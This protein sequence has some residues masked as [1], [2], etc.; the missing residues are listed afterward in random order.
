MLWY[1]SLT[2]ISL[3]I[4]LKTSAAAKCNLISQQSSLQLALPSS[5]SKCFN[6]NPEIHLGKVATVFSG[7][8]RI[9]CLSYMIHSHHKLSLTSG[10]NYCFFFLINN[11]F[12]VG[13]ILPFSLAA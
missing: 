8:C 3:P 4:P 12:W 10:K 5:F 13:K 1:L 7:K 2:W 11:F 9:Q 6:D